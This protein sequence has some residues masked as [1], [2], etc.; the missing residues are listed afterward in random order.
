MEFSTGSYCFSKIPSTA[1]FRH[2]KC[3]NKMRSAAL[4]G[5]TLSITHYFF[6]RLVRGWK[7]PD[8][9]IYSRGSSISAHRHRF[10]HFT[11]TCGP[12]IV[13][14]ALLKGLFPCEGFF[15]CS[16]RSVSWGSSTRGCASTTQS[17]PL[18]DW[19]TDGG[20]FFWGRWGWSWKG[21][22]KR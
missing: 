12:V 5:D 2:K 11:S 8:N 4:L 16:C 6:Y 17:A 20:M 9:L 18:Q 3:I 10:L 21:S 19:Q 22:L 14:F 1:L 13:E 7:R 15:L